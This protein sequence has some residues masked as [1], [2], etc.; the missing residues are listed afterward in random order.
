MLFASSVQGPVS[1]RTSSQQPQ[2]TFEQLLVL[3]LAP[4]FAWG[5]GRKMEAT[6]GIPQILVVTDDL[7]PRPL[8]PNKPAFQLYYFVYLF[9]F[10]IH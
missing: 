8:M 1:Q 4:I 6:F 9:V 5:Y 10:Q 3:H 2:G 7:A